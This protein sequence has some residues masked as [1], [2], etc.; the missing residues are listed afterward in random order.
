MLSLPA[1]R[2]TRAHRRVHAVVMPD[3]PWELLA[4]SQRAAVGLVAD[5]VATMVE[6]GKAGAT[7]PE[8]VLHQVTT[9]ASAVGDLAGATARPLEVF[10]ES[11]RQLAETMAAFAVLQRQ[12]ADVMDTAASNHAAIV[13]ALEM[14]T[15]PVVTVAQRV[16]STSDTDGGSRSGKGSKGGKGSGT[17]Q[18]S[19]GSTGTKGR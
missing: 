7:K 11:Q 13:Q 18:G 8:D 1:W 14:M 6:M 15:A 17:A 19:S 10:L 2:R 12:L 16:R 5:S 4:R 3:N 9:L